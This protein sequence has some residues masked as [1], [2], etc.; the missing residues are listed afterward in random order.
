MRESKGF[1]DVRKYSSQRKNAR[2]KPIP[3]ANTLHPLKPRRRPVELARV[4]LG[5]GILRRR[6]SNSEKPL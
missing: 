4:A 6:Y 3:I 2:L 5:I 1:M